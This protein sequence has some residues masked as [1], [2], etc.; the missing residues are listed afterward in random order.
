[1]VRA[2]AGHSAAK[3]GVS[4]NV[5]NGHVRDVQASGETLRNAYIQ[6]KVDPQTGCITSLFDLRNQM[7]TLAPSETDTGGPRTFACGNLL[8]AFHDKPKQWD[9][10]NIDA[11]FEEQHWD[12]ATADSVALLERGPLRAII[13]VK[14]RFQNYTFVK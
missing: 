8:Q 7:E 5:I 10:W 13:R 2:Y 9:A 1:F 14:E 3:P 6:I 4:P 11:D 12:L